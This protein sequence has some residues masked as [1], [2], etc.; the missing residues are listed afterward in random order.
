MNTLFVMEKWCDGRPDM[1]LT[2]NF[3]NLLGSFSNNVSSTILVAHVDEIALNNNHI[4]NIL[5][6]IVTNYKIDKVIF[7]FLGNSPVNPS[8]DI[9]NKIS[10]KTDLIFMWP[11]TCPPWIINYINSMPQYTHISWAGEEVKTNSKNHRM[12]WTPEDETLYYPDKQDK[13]ATFVGSIRGLNEDRIHYLQYLINNKVEITISGGQ[14]EHKLNY[15]EY[16][17][18]IRSSKININ[19]PGSPMGVDQ[20]KG[21]CLETIASKSLLLEKS[22][23]ITSKFLT[24]GE[25]YIEFTSKEDLKD[26]IDY[27]LKNDSKRNEIAE[28]GYNTYYKKYSSKIFW[29]EVL[30]NV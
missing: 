21:R 8:V 29:N 12:L 3:H 20:F 14:R 22:N 11:D 17:H 25:D 27:L 2:N 30:N 4:N 16:A 18:F 7:S 9:C 6:Q 10:N 23:K 24:P 15:M 19:F 13:N 1:G 5:E 28:N 26:K